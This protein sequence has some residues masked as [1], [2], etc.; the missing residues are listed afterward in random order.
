MGIATPIVVAITV[1]ILYV[2]LYTI[3]GIISAI[4]YATGSEDILPGIFPEPIGE[5]IIKICFYIFT[6]A[7]YVF[8]LLLMFLLI[9]FVIW[10][11]IRYIIPA[12]IW[13]PL[14]FFIPIRAILLAIPPFPELTDA[15]ILPLME[16]LLNVFIS[17]DAFMKRIGISAQAV[18]SFLITSTRYVFGNIFPGYNPDKYYN[19]KNDPSRGYE[20]S[21]KEDT[22]QGTIEYNKQKKEVTD[23]YTNSIISIENEK[24]NCVRKMTKEITPNMDF[25]EKS[26]IQASN[27]GVYA[28]CIAKS[29]S[30]YFKTQMTSL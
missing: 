10:M 22:D 4:K 6:I 11:I 12:V 7:V 20:S 16:R 9:I 24:I 26:Q 28:Q 19:S 3:W 17:S 30:G 8:G 23:F 1:I 27:A 2:V 15:G 5:V 21:K 25:M 13:I 14:F 18:A 29:L